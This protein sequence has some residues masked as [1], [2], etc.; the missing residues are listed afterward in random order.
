M[1]ITC[2][3]LKKTKSI[4]T[5]QFIWRD[6]NKSNKTTINNHNN[7]NKNERGIIR[8]EMGGGGGT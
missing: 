4:Q 1:K 5:T 6:H 2:T 7:E 8:S 3:K